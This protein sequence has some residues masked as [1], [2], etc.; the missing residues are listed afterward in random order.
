MGEGQC[1][2]YAVM[3]VILYV[4]QGSFSLDVELFCLRYECVCGASVV[5][6]FVPI[7]LVCLCVVGFLVSRALV[8]GCLLMGRGCAFLLH[9]CWLPFVVVLALAAF[10]VASLSP[11]YVRAAGFSILP[12]CLSVYLSLTLVQIVCGVMVGCGCCDPVS[13]GGREWEH[14]G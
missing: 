14:D 8:D 10:R 1:R 11:V 3:F 5:Q 9:V 6:G 13:S 7:V 4:V 12:G 2:S